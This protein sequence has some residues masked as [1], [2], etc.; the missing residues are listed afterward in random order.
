MVARPRPR[1]EGRRLEFVPRVDRLHRGRRIR[2]TVALKLKHPDPTLLPALATF[3][4]AI[5]PKKLFEADSGGDARTTR[6]RPSPKS[7]SAPGRSCMSEW[8]RGVS[9]TL[10]RNP[11]YW[12]QGEDGK[13]LPYLDELEF[14]IIPDDAT[15]LLKLKAGEIDG[16]EFVPYVEGAGAEVR[17]EPAHGAMAVDPRRLS[18]DERAPDA[19]GRQAEPAVERQGPAGRSIMP[20]TRTRSSR[21]RRSDLASR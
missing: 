17:S 18:D 14:Q 8:K 15:R 19:E 4:S 2:T 12:K 10:K 13:S 16:T 20:S 5:L 3:N 11:Y 1:P 7:R 9:M 21:S 6:P